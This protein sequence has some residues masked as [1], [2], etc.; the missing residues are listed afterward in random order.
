MT[1][2]GAKRARLRARGFLLLAVVPALLAA[3]SH[4]LGEGDRAPR[5][6]AKALEGEGHVSLEQYRG[7]VVVV[8]FWA[9]WCPPCLTAMPALDGLRKE[10]PSSQFQVVAINVD[11][12][13]DKGRAMLRRLE[14]GYPSASDPE[15]RLPERFGVG[16]MPT[17]YL[18]DRDGVIRHVHEGF[19]R[20]DVDPLRARIRALVAEERR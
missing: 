15:G 3:P 11:S 7:K 16:T 12:D 19:R 9:S 2:T 13:P 18:I 6:Q 8:D 17:S 10:F 1:A 4:A 5:F 14:V 20:G